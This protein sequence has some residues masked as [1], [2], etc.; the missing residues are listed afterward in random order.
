VVGENG[1]RCSNCGST[2]DPPRSRVCGV[3]SAYQP[4]LRRKAYIVVILTLAWFA[5][6]FSPLD[7]ALYTVPV[8]IAVAIVLVIA[9]EVRVMVKERND[10]CEL[11][12][13][14]V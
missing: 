4:R 5:F 12:M 6:E 1:M 11:K 3:C 10:R 8:T 14:E 2:I 13:K 7:Y 9:W